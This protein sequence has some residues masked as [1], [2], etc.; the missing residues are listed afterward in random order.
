MSDLVKVSGFDEG[1]VTLILDRPEKKNALSIALRDQLSD[2]FDRL[3]ADEGVRAVVLAAAGDTFCAGF[4]LAEF[5]IDEPGFQERLWHSADRFHRTVLLFPLPTIAAIQGPALAG[6]FDLAV[7]CDVRVA[8]TDARFG[9]PE[10]KWSDVVFSPLA[11][12][13][14]SGPARDLC[15]TGRTIDAAAALRIGLVSSVVEKGELAGEAARTAALVAGGPRDAL[16][17]TKAKALRRAGHRAETRT[18][19][20]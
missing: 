11:D 8:A 20:L 16:M 7:M 3:A 6:G 15:L 4:D 9:H 10:Q 5:S 19:E 14:G 12:L 17:R 13:V 18:L 2:A 1:V